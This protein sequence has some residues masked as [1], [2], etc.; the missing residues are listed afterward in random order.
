MRSH[1]SSRFACALF[2]ASSWAHA[3]A[4]LVTQVSATRVEV[5]Q[6]FSVQVTCNFSDGSEAPTDPRLPAPRV[7]EVDGPSISSQQSISVVNGHV[8]RKTGL[9]ATWVLA[10]STVGRFRVGPASMMVDGR[11][12]VDRPVEIEVVAAGSGGASRRGRRGRIPFDPFDPFGGGDPFSG[13]MFPPMP[14]FNIDP[15]GMLDDTPTPPPPAEL[16]VTKAKDP[17]AFV[18]ARATPKRVVVGEQV[19]LNVYAY[20]KPGHT[21]A[22]GLTEPSLDGFLSYRSE[23][24]DMLSKTFALRLDDERWF[25]RKILSYALFPTKSGRL[26][27]G[28]AVMTF[29]NQ[30][31]LLGGGGGA[32]ERK[33]DPLTIIVEEPPLAGR[34]AFYHLGDVGQYQL[35][36]TVEP[37]RVDQGEAISVQVEVKGVGQL[38]QRLDPPEQAG[39]D[40]LEPSV[41]Q[42]VDEQR[43]RI[44]GS[45]Q[46]TY[47]V[48][49][50][51]PGTIALGEFKVAYFDPNTRK[52]AVAKAAL[53]NVEVVPKDNATPAESNAPT[54][55]DVPEPFSLSPRGKLSKVAPAPRP[56]SNRAG[57]FYWLA[58]GPLATLFLFATQ[59]TIRKLTL[60]RT[61]RRSSLRSQ[62][63]EELSTAKA[64]LNRGDLSAAAGAVERATHH[65]I[66]ARTG[67]KSRGILRSE[68]APALEAKG[69]PKDFASGLVELLELS[70]NARFLQPDAKATA[71]LYEDAKRL[72]ESTMSRSRT[73]G[74][75]R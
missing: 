75:R 62:V 41:N 72:L 52:Y 71:T 9:V 21:E 14:G 45:R 47:V 24:D 39:V 34:P 46:F 37:R 28:P 10:A 16:D 32:R 70:D 36:A 64:A 56:L 15:R 54:K 69:F 23:H 44:G 68:L 27:I 40:W 33:S 57:F 61:R 17:I 18:E 50:N 12:I 58:L 1:L 5:G 63:D 25:A 8:E 29:A 65:V 35:S 22:V 7:M 43:E 31:A 4:N 6:R 11:R 55:S 60:L 53:G 51:R 20:Y 30:G 2:V 26:T 66:L 48:R 42:Q 73:K 74:G 59:W 49:L 13:P 3:Q 38:P 67:L 19:R